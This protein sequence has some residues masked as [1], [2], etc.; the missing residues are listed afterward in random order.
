MYSKQIQYTV[1]LF[2]VSE[3]LAKYTINSPCSIPQQLLV[4]MFGDCMHSHEEIHA[5]YMGSNS[6]IRYHECIGTG[7][8]TAA[9]PSFEK[10][11]STMFIKRMPRVILLHNHPGGTERFSIA[12]TQLMKRVTEGAKL[13]GLELVDFVLVKHDFTVKSAMH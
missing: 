13:L 7:C 10:L 6:Q 4:E 5:I 11:Y 12:D 3:E 1:K 8:L 9:M 2:Q